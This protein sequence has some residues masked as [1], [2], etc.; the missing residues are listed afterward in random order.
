METKKCPF[1]GDAETY[2]HYN[3]SKY[4]YYYYVKCELC[5]AQTRGVLRKRRELPPVGEEDFEEWTNT[6]ARTAVD[7]WNR[8]CENA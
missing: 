6:A 1:C 8:R 5:G 2:L 7:L 3:G 4:G